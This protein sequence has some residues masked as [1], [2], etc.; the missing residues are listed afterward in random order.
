MSQYIFDLSVTASQMQRYYQGQ[1]QVVVVRSLQGKVIHLHPRFL[2][3]FVSATG[4]HG[5]FRLTLDA[6]G[7]FNEL[8]KIG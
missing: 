6:S 8:I 7:Q 3:P 1:A 4:I 2:R 5:R